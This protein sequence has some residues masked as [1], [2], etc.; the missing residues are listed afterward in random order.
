MLK[1]KAGQCHPQSP[2]SNSLWF[3]SCWQRTGRSGSA[4]GHLSRYTQSLLPQLAPGPPQTPCR[5]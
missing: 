5:C 4:P 1:G 3:H 2:S